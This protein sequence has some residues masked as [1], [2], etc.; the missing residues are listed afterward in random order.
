M[1]ILPSDMVFTGIKLNSPGESVTVVYAL[2][3]NT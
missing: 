1:N 2:T 3:P